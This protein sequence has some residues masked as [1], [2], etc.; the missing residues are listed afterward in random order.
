[1]GF[2]VAGRRC[3]GLQLVGDNTLIY[4]TILTVQTD[5]YARWLTSITVIVIPH[6]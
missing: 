4:Y 3:A 5:D 1:M 6:I 2:D